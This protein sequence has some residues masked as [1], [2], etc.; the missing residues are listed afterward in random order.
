MLLIERTDF[1]PLLIAQRR[2]G[3]GTGDMVVLELGWR[4]DI[5]DGVEGLPPVADAGYT[6]EPVTSTRSTAPSDDIVLR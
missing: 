3:Y 1:C 2:Q 5:D 4:A 6:H